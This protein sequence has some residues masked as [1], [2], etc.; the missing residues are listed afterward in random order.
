L[1]DPKKT[2]FDEKTNTYISNVR[3]AGPGLV[4]IKKRERIT[5]WVDLR[6]QSR[7]R[8]EVMAD[9]RDAIRV[10]TDI[11]C[12]FSLGEPPDVLD[13]CLGGE[14]GKTVFV[15]EWD[16]S[17]PVAYKRIKSLSRELDEGDERE[18]YD[19]MINNLDPISVST[20]VPNSGF[21]YTVDD[22]RIEQAIFFQSLNTDPK[23]SSDLTFRKWSEV[24][25]D[26]VAE[27]FRILLS[28]QPY[29][30]LYSP[31]E[32]DKF[33]LKDLKKELTRQVR[34][35]GVLA[36][37]GIVLREGGSLEAEMLYFTSQLA[38]YP[39]R[40][41]NR[42]DVLRDRGI[43]VHSAGFGELEPV[44]SLVRDHLIKSWRSVKQKK[45]P[46]KWQITTWKLSGSKTRHEFAPNRV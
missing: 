30:K 12:T 16:T 36:Y 26:V 8:K 4:F 27:K 22:Q 32:P 46:L 28:Q 39:P 24:P 40:R 44:E 33:P 14:N 17:M 10:K 20:D 18:I 11:S 42:M 38:F 19:F 7:T 25:V 9:T 34:N 23:A 35:S 3:V 43:K 45:P 21:P 37:R 2:H 1:K 41:L 5:G 6:K 13:V 15:I 29:L 31:E